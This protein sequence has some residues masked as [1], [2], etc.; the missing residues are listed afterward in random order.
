MEAKRLLARQ[1]KLIALTTAQKIP[2]TLYDMRFV[3]KDYSG[4]S[5]FKSTQLP[6]YFNKLGEAFLN[7]FIGVS[8]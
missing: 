4:S 8:F 2:M 3:A 5:E 1:Q 6:I 7:V